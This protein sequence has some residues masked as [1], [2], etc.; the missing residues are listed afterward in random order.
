MRHTL[1]LKE[2][3]MILA[4]NTVSAAKKIFGG[5]PVIDFQM[6]TITC[7][8]AGWCEAGTIEVGGKFI[9]YYKNHKEYVFME[10]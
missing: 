7:A 9:D 2:D 5:N 4:L 6:D 3:G 1:Q 10:A 8:A